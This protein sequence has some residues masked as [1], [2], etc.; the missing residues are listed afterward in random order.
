MN[1]NHFIAYV[2][3]LSNSVFE[4]VELVGGNVRHSIHTYESTGSNGTIEIAVE[5]I[6]F[7]SLINTS[8]HSLNLGSTSYKQRRILAV[9]P[10]ITVVRYCL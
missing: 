9:E 3:T 5:S 6:G 8:N 7:V 4:V 1:S 10:D 2:L